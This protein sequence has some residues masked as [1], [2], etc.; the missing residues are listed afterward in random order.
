MIIYVV[1]HAAP[2]RW[3]G[4]V[5]VE[6]NPR[7]LTAAD[8]LFLLETVLPERQDHRDVVP[9]VRDDPGFVEALIGDERVFQRLIGDEE[10][11]LRVS[12][13]L[14]FSVL[15]SRARKDLEA[16]S[17]TFE[18]RQHQRVAIFDARQAARLIADSPVRNYLA[19]MLASFTKVHGFTRR[20]RVRKGV[21]HRQRFHDLDVDSLIRYA[22][23]I[24]EEYRF[25]VY[26]RIGDVCLFLAG[27][28]PEYIS[29]QQYRFR[30]LAAARLQR[31]LEDYEQQ[32]R[33]FY[34]LAAE[35]RSVR[36]TPLSAPLA[37]LARDFPL[38]EKPLSFLS[39]HYLK[40]RKHTLFEM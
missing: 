21:W 33:A 31:T 2:R 1:S 24:D 38:A 27:V 5:H 29:G 36:G 14:F 26:R 32:G 16:A 13:Q 39:E 34:A 12:P 37:V 11:V 3:I 19:E 35:H 8:I 4:E 18:R 17:Y 28:F 6:S 15:L 9:L 25:E 23:S 40:V 7:L 20:V 22:N 10:M 30:S